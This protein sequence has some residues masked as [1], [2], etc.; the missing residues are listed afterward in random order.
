MLG[1][2][3]LIRVHPFLKVFWHNPV[4][5]DHSELSATMPSFFKLDNVYLC[6]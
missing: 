4:Q 1:I 3:V 5:I 2:E 6:L